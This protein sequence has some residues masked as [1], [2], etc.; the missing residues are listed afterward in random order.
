MAFGAAF[1]ACSVS[2]Q[3]ASAPELGAGTSLTL[4]D[5]SW[6]LVAAS[7]GLYQVLWA[8]LQKAQDVND[9]MKSEQLK[10]VLWDSSSCPVIGRLCRRHM[11]PALLRGGFQ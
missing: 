9:E 4:A 3:A 2:F 10:A 7:G 11:V 5:G 1:H 8:A 6:R